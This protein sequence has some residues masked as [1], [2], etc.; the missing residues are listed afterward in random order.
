MTRAT[1][2]GVDTDRRITRPMNPAMFA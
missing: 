1:L 2:C